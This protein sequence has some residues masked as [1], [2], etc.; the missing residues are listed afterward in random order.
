MSIVPAAQAVQEACRELLLAMTVG[1]L[2]QFEH[3]L[4][5]V[6]HKST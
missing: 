1:E 2:T 5:Q 3:K 6:E 4:T